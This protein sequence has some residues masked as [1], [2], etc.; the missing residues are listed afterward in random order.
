MQNYIKISK[1]TKNR[2]F[3]N[4]KA[5]KMVTISIKVAQNWAENGPFRRKSCLKI[6]KIRAKK[7]E[8]NREICPKKLKIAEKRT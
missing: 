4:Q 5:T 7:C 6:K 2:R 3:I 1:K 8:Q